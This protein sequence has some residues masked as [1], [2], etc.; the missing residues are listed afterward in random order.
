[1]ETSKKGDKEK[2]TKQGTKE[3]ETQ[4]WESEQAGEAQRG[5]AGCGDRLQSWGAPGPQQFL[6]CCFDFLLYKLPFDLQKSW[7]PEPAKPQS[8]QHPWV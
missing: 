7:E 2:D 5:Q 8:Q 6:M 3:S 1:M 4:V